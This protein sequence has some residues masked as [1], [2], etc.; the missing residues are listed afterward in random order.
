ML[1]KFGSLKEPFLFLIS[2]D[3][4]KIYIEKLQNLSQNIKFEIDSK[5]KKNIKDYSLKKYPISFDEYKK[6]F[7]LIQDEIK[8]GNSY[9]LNLTAQ[10]KIDTNLTLDDIYEASSSLLKLRVKFDDLDFVCFSPEK[11]ID[12]K[13]NKI[14]TYPMKG[15]ID[16][17]LTDAKNILLNNKKELAEH[18][19]VVDLLRNDLGKVA[20]NIKV[21]EFRT[22]SKIVTKDSELFQTSSII[23]GD[24]QN[25]WQEKIGDILSNILPAGSITGTPKKSTIEILKNIENYDRGFYSGIF[26]IFDGINLQSF[27]L[28]RFIENINNE[29]FYKSGGGITSDSIANEE[30][31]EL[32][33]KVYLPF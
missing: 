16:S 11:F 6:K 5:N 33:N 22:F 32:L 31:E 19:M 23:S 9:L 13:D 14:Y 28:I 30:Y 2:Y 10:T 26:G 29:L 25:N 12:I 21:E 20:N 27:V 3:L 17:N 8:N 18:T 15:T 7:D 4:E 24:L 1:N